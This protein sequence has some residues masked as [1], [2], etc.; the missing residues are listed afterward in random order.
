MRQAG[1]DTD[2]GIEGG[3]APDLDSSIEAIEFI[4]AATIRAGYNPGKDLWLGLDIGSN[5]LFDDFS[6]RYIFPLDKTYFSANSLLG[7]YDSWLKKYPIIYL[8][9][10]FA[11]DDWDNWRALTSE[12][13]DKLMVAGDDL[14]VSSSKRLRRGIKEQAA[15]SIVV[16]PN[17]VG[18][19]T[20]TMDCIKL[21]NKHN[22]KV[23]ISHR[24]GETNDDFIV[25]LAVAVSADYLKAGS[26][27]RGE[28]V[29]KYN[30]LLIIA[31]ILEKN[32]K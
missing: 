1:L 31:E 6:K 32:G 13:G 25:D 17:Q 24:S 12:M 7:L 27:S 26:L 2:T 5:V 16:A 4:L 10:A 29:A 14:F 15:N 8:E 28:R 11:E 21:A 20:E 9:D 23:I 30:R 22:F 18:T 3:Y 19:L